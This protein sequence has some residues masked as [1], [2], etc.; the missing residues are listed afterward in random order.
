MVVDNAEFVEKK[1]SGNS[2]NVKSNEESASE[3]INEL[4]DAGSE[5]DLPF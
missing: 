3:G 5:D 1:G 4:A 2:N